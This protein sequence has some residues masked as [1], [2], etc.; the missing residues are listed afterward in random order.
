MIAATDPRRSK[1]SRARGIGRPTGRR[2]S[3]AR[4]LAG[5][6]RS[7]RAGRMFAR[8]RQERRDADRSRFDATCVKQQASP[9]S[10]LRWSTTSR[11]HPCSPPTSRS[12]LPL[13]LGLNRP[14]RTSATG[15]LAWLLWMEAAQTAG[16]R[17]GWG[18]RIRLVAVPLPMVAAVDALALYRVRPTE[19]SATASPRGTQGKVPER[20][21]PVTW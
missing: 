18:S 5:R 6:W 3:R 12:S 14:G 13:L 8:R 2:A 15:L 7:R 20:H 4:E 9:R 11:V 1:R 21:P 10:A 19:Q 16:A 17:L